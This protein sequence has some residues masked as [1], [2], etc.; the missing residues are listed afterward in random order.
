MAL[1]DRLHISW[2]NE[3]AD[4][5]ITSDRTLETQY[6]ITNAQNGNSNEPAVADMTGQISWQLKGSD[7]SERSANCFAIHNHNLGTD[8]TARLRLYAGENQTGNVEYD[9]TVLQIPHTIPFGSI[10]AGR[11]PVGG[12][13]E[14]D[15]NLR[16]HFSDWFDTVTYKSWQI[17]LSIPTPV[18]DTASI[19]KFW[20]GHAWAPT[21]GPEYGH[22]SR[23]VDPSRHVRKPGGGME[24]IEDFC[25]RAIDLDFSG[26]PST[27]R[28]VVR[29]ILD[30]ARKGGDILVT[31]DPNNNLSLKH[32]MTSIYRRTSDI[33]FIGEYFNGHGFGLSLEEN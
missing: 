18:N 7:S 25:Y 20:L 8:A 30:Q 9:S 29:H 13:F 11:D 1:V 26:H 15:G 5:I 33:S 19:D 12:Y 3:I 17:D 24:T 2:D 32:E 10:L 31:L 21:Y 6:P 23:I 4:F 27:D 16:T 14:T 28:H 22:R